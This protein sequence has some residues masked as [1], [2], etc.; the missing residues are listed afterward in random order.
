[1]HNAALFQ[2]AQPLH[3][4]LRYALQVGHVTQALHLELLN[5]FV[6]IAARK[7]LKDEANV[8]AEAESAQQSHDPIC[9]L[10]LDLVGLVK[11]ANFAH[12]VVHACLH[13]VFAHLDSHM[14]P[15]LVV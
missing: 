14:L 9:K 3:Y 1:M 8:L 15:S 12:A 10:S 6:K 13:H 5:L 4:L 7:Q 11:Q 2:V